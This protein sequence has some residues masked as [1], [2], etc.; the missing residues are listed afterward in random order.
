MGTATPKKRYRH[1]VW[2]WNGTLFDDAAL[3]VEVMNGLLCLRAMP[4]LSPERY[5][6]LFDFPVR[7]YYLRLGFD[8]A[9]ES[10]ER[11]GAEFIEA[12]ERRRLDAPLRR[13]A[14]STLE[15]LRVLGVGQS[16][17]SAY[18][19]V[20]LEELIDF[21]GLRPFFVRLTGAKDLYAFGKRAEGLACL[22]GLNAPAAEVLFIGDTVHDYEVA[23]A[24]GTDCVLLCGGH[25]APEK[26][27]A[28]GAP[29]FS[30]LADLSAALF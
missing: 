26:L 11:L 30:T 16:V 23:R 29:V 15:R 28:T 8:F 12:Y 14:L 24:M 3:C 2:D 6:A 1:V 9:Q 22:E 19:Q 25:Q 17:L 20:S 13:D 27:A 5:R 21:F 4:P 7:D 10:F 18:R